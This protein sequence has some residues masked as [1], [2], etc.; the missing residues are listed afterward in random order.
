MKY[1]YTYSNF[2]TPFRINLYSYFY[3]NQ[4]D[5]RVKV[6]DCLYFLNK[7]NYFVN[8]YLK[9]NDNKDIRIEMDYGNKNS[10]LIF[11]FPIDLYNYDYEIITKPNKNI[12]TQSKYLIFQFNDDFYSFENLK[13]YSSKKF[14]KENLLIF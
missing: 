2:S 8:G 3:I 6:D 5:V 1:L 10:I 14:K 4:D 13:I 11:Y 7:N 9:L 12:I